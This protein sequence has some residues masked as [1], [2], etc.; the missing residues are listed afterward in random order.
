[1]FALVAFTNAL[2]LIDGIDGL[3]GTISLVIIS[4]FGY[5]GYEY[6]NTLMMTLSA[7]TLASLLSFMILNYPPAK[8]FMG[9]SGS[10]SL[11]FIIALLAILS[12][13]YIHPIGILYLAALPIL[14]TL[15]VTIRRARRGVSIL[16]PD[17]THIHHLLLRYIGDKDEEG[18]IINGNKRTVW[19]LVVFQLLFA[20]MG[21]MMSEYANAVPILALVG[22][23]IIFIL[24]YMIFTKI[25]KI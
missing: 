1:M 24:T 8:I 7:F 12:I 3:A 20:V 14:D 17:K 11:G 9:D 6:S 23:A 22:F 4:S 2:N 19:V 25:E 18:H 21:L 5:I 13:E 16:N 10:L 15:I